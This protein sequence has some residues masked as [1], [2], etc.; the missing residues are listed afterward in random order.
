M[1]VPRTGLDVED[2]RDGPVV[3]EVDLHVGAEDAALH[4]DAQG[5]QLGAVAVE[6]RLG[7]FLRRRV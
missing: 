1:R 4:G 5:R 7:F 6:E 2:D 3:D